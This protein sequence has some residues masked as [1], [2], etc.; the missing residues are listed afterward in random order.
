MNL[1]YFFRH[2]HKKRQKNLETKKVTKQRL[3]KEIN[4]SQ[5]IFP[6]QMKYFFY[7]EIYGG[8]QEIYYKIKI[9]NHLLT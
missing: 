9:L 7:V 3:S 8:Y 1:L 4:F 6:A 5:N 2:T